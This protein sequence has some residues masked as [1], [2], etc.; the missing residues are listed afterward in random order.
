MNKT[1]VGG[2]DIG[3]SHITVGLVDLNKGTLIDLSLRREM[4]NSNDGVENVIK[5]WTAVILESF[6]SVNALPSRIAISMPGPFDYDKGVCLIKDQ[7][8]YDALFGL[9]VKELLSKSLSIGVEDIVLINDALC[10]LQG[11]I[12]GGAAKGLVNVIGLTLGTGLGSSRYRN[13]EV[14]DANL[15]CSSFKNGIAEDYISTRW[16]L[17]RYHELT[18][19][20]VPG[21]KEIAQVISADKYSKQVFNEFGKNLAEFLLPQV[22]EQ[23]PQLVVLGGNI[24]QALPHFISA[25]DKR[26]KESN[27]DIKIKKAQFG[28]N[29]AL[30][31]AASF[32]QIP[33]ELHRTA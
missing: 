13:G 10:F 23:K 25:F 11:E 30:M 28:E 33:L 26:V 6:K 21:V 14:E 2:V 29:A 7:N 17:K 24:S 4:V 18:K 32:I 8:K 1:I 31:G 19:K 3:G 22:I 5:T 16:F 20:N 15:W 9:N 12:F 27:I